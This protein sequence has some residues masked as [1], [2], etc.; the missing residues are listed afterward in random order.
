MLHSPADEGCPQARSP[1]PPDRFRAGCPVTRYHYGM[2]RDEPVDVRCYSGHTYAQ[3]PVAFRWHGEEIEVEEVFN[4][5]REPTGP[6][7]RVRT[8]RGV[9]SLA[10]DTGVDRWRLRVGTRDTT[11][12]ASATLKT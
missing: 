8:T 7:F 3:R 1:G 2:Q 10:Y 9:F 5:W 12:T 11:S 4:S 6:V